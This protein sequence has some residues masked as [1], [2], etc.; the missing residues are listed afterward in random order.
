MGRRLVSIFGV[1]PAAI[2]VFDPTE[3]LR[4]RE[5]ELY[6]LFMQTTTR[7]ISTSFPNPRETEGAGFSCTNGSVLV[8]ILGFVQAIWTKVV[9]T[10]ITG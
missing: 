4:Q 6:C 8:Q 1:V 3:S 10:C 7:W 2:T 5:L 9:C